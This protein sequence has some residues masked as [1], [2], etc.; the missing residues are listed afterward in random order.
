MNYEITVSYS[1]KKVTH[2]IVEKW[3]C[4]GE[5]S[6]KRTLGEALDMQLGKDR[7]PV[8]PTE[9]RL[10]ALRR[11]ADEKF[12]KDEFKRQTRAW[13]TYSAAV[14]TVLGGAE[15]KGKIDCGTSILVKGVK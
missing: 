3:L 15:A 4:R 1:E 6:L 14:R 2:T 7:I 9:A 11:Y 8:E 12:V 5:K 10:E 13:K